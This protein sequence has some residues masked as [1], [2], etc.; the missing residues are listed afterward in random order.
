MKNG[1]SERGITA[2]GLEW[3]REHLIE[4]GDFRK[5]EFPGLREDRIPV[6]TG[7]VAIMSAVFD[8]LELE[9]MMVAEG[10]LRYWVLCDLLGRVHHR[11]IL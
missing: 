7:G 3:L 6:V 9:D 4:A 8:E 11:Y 10:A 2:T 5:L 1:Q